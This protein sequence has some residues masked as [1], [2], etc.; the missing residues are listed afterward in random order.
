MNKFTLDK[1]N[2]GVEA[3]R[4]CGSTLSTK[5]FKS[6]SD[7]VLYKHANKSLIKSRQM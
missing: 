4:N 6:I 7:I 3:E 1:K 2:K 5:Q